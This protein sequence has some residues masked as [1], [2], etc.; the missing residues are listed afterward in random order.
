MFYHSVLSDWNHGNA[1]LLRGVASE[2]IRRGHAVT[3]YEPVDAW[4]RQN[5]IAEHGER[6]IEDFYAYYPQLEPHIYDPQTLDLNAALANCDLVLVHEWNSPQLV[7]A[8]GRHRRRSGDYTLLF[9]D[10]HHR[11]INDG[12]DFAQ[13]G[14]GL[15]DGVLAFG[16]SLRRAHRNRGWARRVW[17]WHEAADTAYFYPIDGGQ[18]AGDLV[19]IGNWGDEE[20]TEE[21]VQ[22]LVKPTREL[23]LR[24][25]VYGVRYTEEALAWLDW[26]GIR[27]FGY[28]P[29]FKVPEIFGQYRATVHVPRRPYTRQLS[30]I[31]TIRPFEALAC[32]M[33]LLS[34]GWIGT[35][36]LFQPGRD[37]AVA[38][39]KEQMKRQIAAVLENEGR[40]QSMAARGRQTILARH[41]C[42]HRVN[43]LLQICRDDLGIDTTPTYWQKASEPQCATE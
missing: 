36:G 5:L 27:H 15:Y 8:I 11:C 17:T 1:H 22:F 13:C 41:T 21:L 26:A 16:E 23:G 19:W 25:H 43:E 18:P 20:R 29:N 42:H 35:G 7:R 37:F 30:D 10:T 34:A 9:H 40:G 3:I 2:L 14:L 24:T 33:P 32:G 4:S 38:H 6:V 39:A 31:P 28:L 12:V